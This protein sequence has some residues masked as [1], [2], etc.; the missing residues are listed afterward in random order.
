[1]ARL[2]ALAAPVPL[3]AACTA[4][5]QAED[6]SAQRAWTPEIFAMPLAEPERFYQ[7]TGVDHDPEDH[8]DTPLGRAVCTD[9]AGRA[10]PWC[11]DGHRGS[12]YL[13]EGGFDA[14]DAGSTP[15]LAAADGV[16]IETED[17][18]YDR[19]HIDGLEVSCDGYPMRANFVKLEHPSGVRTWYWHMKTDSVAVEVG[20]QVRCGDVL[21][22]VGSSGNSST[23]HL[24]FE[25]RLQGEAV[26]PYAGPYSQPESWWAEQGDDIEELPLGGCP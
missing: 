1:M 2:L 19:C 3:L 23:P 6:T 10:F 20:Q 5:P 14:M 18:H 4:L 11:Y 12:D 25:V 9:Y 8:S 7:T 15:I 17:G 16:V 13:L 24:H 26:D 22:L 21:G